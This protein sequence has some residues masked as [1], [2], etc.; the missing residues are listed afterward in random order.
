MQ[1]PLLRYAAQIGWEYVPAAEALRR[2]QGDTGL[3]FGAVLAGQLERLNPSV[4]D[5][6]RAAEI[7]R[8]LRLLPPSIAGNA[9]ALEWLRG[10]RSVFVPGERRERTCD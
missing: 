9:A 10:E 8:Q 7:G 2:R 6:A 4:V 5:A 3:Y 1:N